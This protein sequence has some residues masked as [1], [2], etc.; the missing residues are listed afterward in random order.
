MKT[1]PRDWVVRVDVNQARSGMES[2][3]GR[4]LSIASRQNPVTGYRR[5]ITRELLGCNAV[6][7]FLLVHIGH[8]QRMGLRE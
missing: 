2:T 4:S 8:P 6:L 5:Q 1:E 7:S 3:A